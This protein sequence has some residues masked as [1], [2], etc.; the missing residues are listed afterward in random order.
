MKLRQTSLVATLTLLLASCASTN[1]KEWRG[2]AVVEGI[3]GTVRVVD[4]IDF[5]ETGQPD[6]KF[7]IIGT[8]DD[9][10]GNGILGRLGEDSAIA[11]VAKA[12]G[13]DGVLLVGSDLLFTGM[14]EGNALYQ[15]H[16]KLVVVKYL[17]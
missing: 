9:S 12:H 3:G 1:F 14:H 4:G 2:H 7:R 16:T 11:K 8:I 15:R 17:P 10:R 13:G 5:W 6:R